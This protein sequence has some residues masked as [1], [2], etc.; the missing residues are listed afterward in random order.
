MHMQMWKIKTFINKNVEIE[1]K[2]STKTTTF[3]T[4]KKRKKQ[5]NNTVNKVE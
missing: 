4:A 2:E 1:I 5:K 3:V